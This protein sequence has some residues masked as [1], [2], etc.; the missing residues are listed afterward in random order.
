MFYY[1][2]IVSTAVPPGIYTSTPVS[3]LGPVLVITVRRF[4]PA[5][6][7]IALKPGSNGPVEVLVI[8]D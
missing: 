3:G 1:I 6:E 7:D 5:P 2:N 8:A 4:G